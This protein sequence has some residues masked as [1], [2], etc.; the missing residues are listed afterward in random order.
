MELAVLAADQRLRQPVWVVDEVEREA[1]LDAQVALVGHIR[2]IRC[3]LHDPLRLGIDVEVDLAANAAE[4]AGRLRLHE[5]LLAAGRRALLELL[6]D[7]AGRAGREAAA[8]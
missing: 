5:R 2:R 3:D 7:R 1:A 6:V 4:R 8:A